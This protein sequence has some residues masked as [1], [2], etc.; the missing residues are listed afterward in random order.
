MASV[1]APVEI[2]GDGGPLR[3]ATDQVRL[4]FGQLPPRQPVVHPIDRIP[5]LNVGVPLLVVVPAH[6]FPISSV[7]AATSVLRGAPPSRSAASAAVARTLSSPTHARMA[8]MVPSMRPC[9][10]VWARI[11][12]FLATF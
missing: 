12:A 11:S 4:L 1:L 3:Q 10:S 5:R 8:E 9:A 7:S 2:T 6:Q